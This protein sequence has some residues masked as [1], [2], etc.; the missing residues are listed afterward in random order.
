MHVG[1]G[2]LNVVVEVVAER[3]QKVDGLENILRV[4]VLLED[5][6]GDEA[7]ALNVLQASVVL[8]LEWG[9]LVLK[10]N[11]GNTTHVLAGV[12]KLLQ[13]D[14]S[15]DGIRIIREGNGVDNSAAISLGLQ[16]DGLIASVVQSDNLGAGSLGNNVSEDL[17][18]RR[19]KQVAL[20]VA[21]LQGEVL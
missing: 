21:D 7:V 2:A 8:Q 3:L 17:L 6:H 12:S 15:E 4:Q 20:E 1:L 19:S 11:G 13:E 18:E 5:N 10:V 9:L 14:L 16:V